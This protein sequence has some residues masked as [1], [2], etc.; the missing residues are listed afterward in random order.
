VVISAVTGSSYYTKE[1]TLTPPGNPGPT[2]MWMGLDLSAGT[3]HFMQLED[4]AGSTGRNAV[5]RSIL[6]ASGL[7][8]A[9]TT[10][11]LYEY[12]SMG[13]TGIRN[14]GPSCWSGSQWNC[15]Y[16]LHR[17]YINGATDVAYILTNNS[18]P[19]DASGTTG[20]PTSY[21]QYTGAAKPIE[22]ASC[23]SSSCS[24][25]L[26]LSMGLLGQNNA[27]GTSA[28]TTADYNGCVNASTRVISTDN[29]L[30]CSLTGVSINSGNTSGVIELSRQFYGGLTSGAPSILTNTNG[31][32]TLSFTGASDIYTAVTAQ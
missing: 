28:T 32:T 16:E 7:N 6:S 9:A 8:S 4:Q 12:A 24:Q 27:N 25:T 22:L 5:D 29:S 26:A 1:I 3:L 14:S 17:M 18:P 20:A 31:N 23:T 10:V 2:H 19:G 21:V 30:S 15:D 13:F 11:L